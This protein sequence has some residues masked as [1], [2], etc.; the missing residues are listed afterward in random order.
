[1]LTLIG[2][3]FNKKNKSSVTADKMRDLARKT[4]VDNVPSVVQ[5]ILLLVSKEAKQGSRTLRMN[6]HNYD[7]QLRVCEF[8]LPYIRNLTANYDMVEEELK[9]RGFRVFIKWS[10]IQ[11]YW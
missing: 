1:M 11:V 7:E 2:K 8:G 3:I 10:E 6:L 9:N 5:Q 4:S